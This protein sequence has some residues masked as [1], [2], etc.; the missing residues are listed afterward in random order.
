LARVAYISHPDFDLHVQGPH[1]P[2]RPQRTAAIAEYLPTTDIWHDL[3]RISPAKAP[4]EVL[5]LVHPSPYVEQITSTCARGGGYVDGIETGVVRESFD[6]ALRAVGAVTG[7][8]DAVLTGDV[9]RAF[10]AVRPP[11][12]HAKIDRAMGFC[13]FNNIAIGARYAQEKYGVERVLIVDWDFHH[14]N[15]TQEA[16]WRDPSVLF[17]SVH[18]YPA[19]PFSGLSGERGADE[20]LG[21]T[22]NAPLAPG[23]GRAEYMD[24]IENLLMLAAGDFQPE[25][26]LIS[27]GF[28]AHRDDPLSLFDLRDDDFRTLTDR[29]VDIAGRSAAGRIVSVL[30][31]GY[32]LHALPRSVEQ[33]LRGMLQ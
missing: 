7:A 19:F 32:D 5:L 9:D 6:I 18:C 28:D 27:A 1:H 29:V 31:G 20:G 22:L 11:G 14:G 8:V 25:L 3:I 30:E 2:E 26:V 15:G 16:F 4:P 12:H 33:H 13:L 17:F 24:I 10:C 23:S 21:Y